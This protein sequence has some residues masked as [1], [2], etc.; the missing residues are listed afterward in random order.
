VQAMIASQRR[1]FHD[2]SHELRS[3]LARMEAAVGLARQSPERVETSL[4]RIERESR[5]LDALVGEVLTLAR[6]DS[7]V[8][9]E[10]PQPT[11]LAALLASVVDDARFEGER[12]GVAVSS[13]APETLP[14]RARADDL[15]RAFDNVVRNALRFAPAGSTIDITLKVSGDG[16]FALLTVDDKG[17]GLRPDELDSVF[18]RFVR[19]DSGST[20][21]GF[22]LGLA[23]AERAVRAHDGT[24]EASNR[25]EG[26]LRIAITLPL[27]KS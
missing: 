18:R 17:P 10:A 22:G 27:G 20:G 5:R 14:M 26:G 16:K 4:D 15:L 24:I 11:D 13:T 12:T 3:P 2:V 19:A 1:L 25:P 7:G 8:D 23:I 21:T 6:L 9:D